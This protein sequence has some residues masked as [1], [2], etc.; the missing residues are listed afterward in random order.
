MPE[1]VPTSPD[2]T[3]LLAPAP[4]VQDNPSGGGDIDD[5]LAVFCIDVSGSMCVTTEVPGKF[6]VKG[7]DKKPGSESFDT[8]GS[9]QYLPRERRDITYVSRLQVKYMCTYI[10]GC[11]ICY[12]HTCLL[13]Y[14]SV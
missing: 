12:L 4:A 2:T 6:K 1:E 3:Y 10:F 13:D 11:M 5:T 9:N 14:C 8:D 7:S